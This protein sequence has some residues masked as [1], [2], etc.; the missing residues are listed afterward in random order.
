MGVTMKS[1]KLTVCAF[2]LMAL[3]LLV[4]ACGTTKGAAVGI[5]STAGLFAIDLKTADTLLQS[6]EVE[7]V[8]FKESLSAEDK[9]LLSA[10][11]VESATIRAEIRDLI[12]SPE[13]L[14]T[15]DVAIQSIYLRTKSIYG[16][17][18]D[19]V[20]RN[21]DAYTPVEHVVLGSWAARVSS[22]DERYLDL[23]SRIKAEVNRD[24][25]TQMTIEVVKVLVQLAALGLGA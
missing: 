21:P 18:S 24:A 7:K 3:C 10:A 23:V 14:A 9:V 8:L 16:I 1:S 20:K 12:K 2:T 5:A 13:K 6:G 19:V 17:A 22:A 25:R 15:A 4:T 11:G